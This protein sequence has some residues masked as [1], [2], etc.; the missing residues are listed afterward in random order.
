MNNE[1][2]YDFLIWL[3]ILGSIVF[4]IVSIGATLELRRLERRN[5]K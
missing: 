2:P 4:I 1:L 5:K 3:L